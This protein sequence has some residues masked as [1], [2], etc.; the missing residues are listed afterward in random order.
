MLYAFGNVFLRK[1]S[2]N[3]KLSRVLSNKIMDDN[4]NWWHGIHSTHQVWPIVSNTMFQNMWAS[5]QKKKR[6][7]CCPT[8]LVSDRCLIF[9]F[10]HTKSTNNTI[11][12][13]RI[14]ENQ[15]LLKDEAAFEQGRHPL[16]TKRVGKE[17]RYQTGT[18]K[19][20]S[21]QTW[22]I[23]LNGR[24]SHRIFHIPPRLWSWALGSDNWGF[25]CD[26]PTGEIPGRWGAEMMREAEDNDGPRKL[27][28]VWTSL[29]P[30]EVIFF[31]NQ[32]R[33]HSW[34]AV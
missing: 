22:N 4:L 28:H 30:E 15:P 29:R 20:I 11:W 18:H 7:H 14:D 12:S 26:G 9:K 17:R 24:A 6:S 33:F 13:R 2:Q 34:G 31:W 5:K 1:V 21:V 32:S 27:W 3:F 23:P 16:P 19:G 10:R 25:A 8:I